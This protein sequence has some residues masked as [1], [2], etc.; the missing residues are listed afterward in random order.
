[1][2]TKKFILNL[3]TNLCERNYAE[4]NKNLQ[5]VIESKLRQKIAT[6]VEKKAS[7]AQLAARK[8]FLEKIKA[9][10]KGGMKKSKNQ[11]DE[12]KKDNWGPEERAKFR[13]LYPGDK[14]GPD[15]IKRNKKSSRESSENAK[16]YEDYK[17]RKNNLKKGNK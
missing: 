3:I 10:K 7:P 12:N 1:M 6:L 9:K 16:R 15:A 2:E 13:K 4:A 5:A 14:S 8:K 17:T 11:L